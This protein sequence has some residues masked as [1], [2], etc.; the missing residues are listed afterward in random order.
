MN[1]DGQSH[2]DIS[3]GIESAVDV[4]VAAIAFGQSAGDGKPQPR[5]L[6]LIGLAHKLRVGIDAPHIF[7]RYTPSAIHYMQ[8]P[9]VIFDLAGDR[10]RRTGVREL[11]GVSAFRYGLLTADYFAGNAGFRCVRPQ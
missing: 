2:I 5:A 4:Q 9:M 1:E 11:E 6:L 10:H 3:A 7:R 8:H